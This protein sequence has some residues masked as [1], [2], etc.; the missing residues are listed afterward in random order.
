LVRSFD[1]KSADTHLRDQ[2]AL[3]LVSRST[4][5]SVY[6]DGEMASVTMHRLFC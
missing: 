6:G 4:N 3:A 5:E 2:H 1:F